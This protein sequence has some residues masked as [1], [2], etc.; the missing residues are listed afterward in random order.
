MP[1]VLVAETPSGDVRRDVTLADLMPDV[2]EL[3]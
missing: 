2:F 3:E 1:V